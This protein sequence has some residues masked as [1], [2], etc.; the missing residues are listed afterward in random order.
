MTMERQLDTRTGWV[1]WIFFAGFM[2]ILV[3]SLNLIYGLVALFN[4]EW[5]VWGNR[6]SVLLDITAWGW[7]HAAL[8]AIVILAGIGIMTGNLAARIVAVIVVGVSLIVNFAAI[9]VYP[10]WSLV[11]IAIELLVLWALIVHGRELKT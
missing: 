5:V 2:M 3:G 4:D 11:A 1:G 6:G 10:V 7:I 9:P 8:G